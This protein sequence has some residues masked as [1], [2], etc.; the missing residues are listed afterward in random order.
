MRPGTTVETSDDVHAAQVVARVLGQVSANVAATPRRCSREPVASRP[1][2]DLIRMTPMATAPRCSCSSS[3]PRLRS[4][5][6]DAAS[7]ATCPRR[8]KQH[9][10]AMNTKKLQPPRSE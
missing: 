7:G 3:Q 9:G 5:R 4:K 1:D 8:A 6:P 2:A 10:T